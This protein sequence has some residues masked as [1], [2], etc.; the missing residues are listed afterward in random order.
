METKKIIVSAGMGRESFHSNPDYWPQ[1]YPCPELQ[2]SKGEVVEAVLV[3]QYEHPVRKDWNDT[4]GQDY[5]RTHHTRQIYRLTPK[6]EKADHPAP[7]LTT[8]ELTDKVQYSDE[9]KGSLSDEHI[10]IVNM[11]ADKEPSCYADIADIMLESTASKDEEIKRLREALEKIADM[12]QEEYDAEC[13]QA[14]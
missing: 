13:Y 10:K 5:D 3:K 7:L 6:E 11:L 2:D 1:S 12:L 14:D 4:N 9:L 8:E